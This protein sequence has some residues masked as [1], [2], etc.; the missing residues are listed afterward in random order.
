MPAATS[1]LPE[2]TPDVPPAGESSAGPPGAA[3]SAAHVV[4]V[5]GLSWRVI[6]GAALLSALALWASQAPLEA[7]PL[8]FV[9]LVPLLVVS[10]STRTGLAAGAVTGLVYFG[11][12][13]RWVFEFGWFAWLPVVAVLT[14]ELVAFGA[15]AGLLRTR[16]WSMLPRVVVLSSA[17][18]VWE[19]V[20]D[21]FPLNGISWG[22]IG[23]SQ[24][25]LAFTRASAALGGVALLT[26]LV[27]AVN[28]AVA[29]AAAGSGVRRCRVVSAGAVVGAVVVVFTA[30]WIMRPQTPSTGSLATAIVQ[31]NEFEGRR[32]DPETMIAAHESAT[33]ALDRTQPLDLVVWGE[34]SLLWSDPTPS[35]ARRISRAAGGVPLVANAS[36]PDPDTPTFEN[37][38]FLVTNGVFAD[39]YV[40]RHLVPFGEFVPWPWLRG[41][42]G[43]L[44]QVPRDAR[45]GESVGLFEVAGVQLG[46]VT[47]FETV[48]ADPSRELANAGA[49]AFVFTTNNASFGRSDEPAQYLALTRLRAAETH[50]AISLAAVS[51]SSATID[52]SGEILASTPLFETATLRWDMPLQ[53]DS[54]VF[55][56]LGHWVLWLSLC[57][58]ASWPVVVIVGK[59]SPGRGSPS[60]EGARLQ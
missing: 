49:Q 44:S 21:R 4:P 9:A 29:D 17:L 59:R 45:P 33:R 14:L 18:V 42:I 20:R 48:F 55:V 25:S 32:V 52:A 56:R 22:E 60:P 38:T 16:R 57:I 24:G 36:V 23:V 6:T 26:W 2:P 41:V 39:E 5:R 7:G 10:R 27:V 51:G 13:L 30:G 53:E 50:R 43:S 1:S 19:W 40:K 37:T 58:L 11:L 34:S 28:V 12:L 8:A 15:L 3:A 46:T 31:A 35:L 54:T 47:C